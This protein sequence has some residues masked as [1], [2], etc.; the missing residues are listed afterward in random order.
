[1]AHPNDERGLI[2][3]LRRGDEATFASLVERYQPAL[4]RVAMI[5]VHDRAVA[6]EVV[7]EAW[8][9]M[10]TGLGR[11]AGRASLKTWLF[12]ILINC[13]KAS[14]RREARAIPFSMLEETTGDGSPSVA[15]ECFHPFGHRW[16]GHWATP[17]DEWPE[18]RLLA[19]ET[20]QRVEQAVMHLPPHQRAVVTLR[21]L[22]GWTAD[23]V[24][25]VLEISAGNQRVLLHRAR[26]HV[27]HEIEAF[28][29]AAPEGDT[30]NGHY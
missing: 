17:P 13:A 28:V 26:S 18:A 16:A 6:E 11:F 21:D 7:Q 3:A 15:P 2:D 25:D 9:G 14:R 19:A 23:E 10:L 5:Y 27:R 20:Q 22:E 8:L 1:L 30:I 29:N 24:C 4:V 12:S